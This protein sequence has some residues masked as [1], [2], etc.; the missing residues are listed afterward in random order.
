M[1]I[2]Y[3]ESLIINPTPLKSL[4]FHELILIQLLFTVGLKL[5]KLIFFKTIKFKSYWEKEYDHQVD[6]LYIFESYLDLQQVLEMI[7]T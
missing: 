3:V 6:I 5:N 2:F 1:R 7:V 4:F